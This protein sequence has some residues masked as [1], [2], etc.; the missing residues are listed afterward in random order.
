MF[1]TEGFEEVLVF[2]PYYFHQ[3][4][5][6]YFENLPDDLLLFRTHIWWNL[7]IKELCRTSV[8]LVFFMSADCISVLAAVASVSRAGRSHSSGHIVTWFAVRLG[9]P[10]SQPSSSKNSE[11]SLPTHQTRHA[12][13]HLNI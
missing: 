5:L 3:H 7:A 13:K 8:M 4:G 6:F 1:P 12:F 10:V 9:C 2:F 11:A